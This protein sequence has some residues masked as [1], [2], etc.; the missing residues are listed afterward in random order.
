[1]LNRLTDLESFCLAPGDSLRAV[2]A[3]IDR[4]RRGIALVVDAERRLIGTVTDGDLR[5][6][7]LASCSL[8]EP[9][10]AVLAAQERRDSRH[11]VHRLRSRHPTRLSART[12]HPPASA[13]R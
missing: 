4:N 8:D 5:R 7:I 1:M 12:P 13:A 9:V 10:S 6:A 2:L 3:A 11:R